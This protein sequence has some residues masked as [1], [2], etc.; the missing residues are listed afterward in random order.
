MPEP[1]RWTV[2]HG[3]FREAK[4]APESVDL[5]FTDPPYY[6]SLTYLY[7]DLGELAQRVL[8]PGGW[9][10]AYTGHL[11]LPEALSLMGRFGL[12]WGLP[13]CVRHQGGL[14]CLTKFN[15]W[16]HYKVILG[17]FKPPLKVRWE[18]FD[19]LIEGTREKDL[20]WMQQGQSEAERFIKHLCPAGGLVLDPMMG[21]GTTLAAALKLG[22]RCIGFDVDASAYEQ[23]R[24]WLSRTEEPRIL[25]LPA[26][27]G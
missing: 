21:S 13:L 22:L 12:Q 27:A 16:Q 15:V 1:V 26:A 5:I 4:I 18:A 3:D 10:L 14:L 17:F 2:K 25:P 20:H 7:Q 8:K 6:P 24:Q 23:A 11:I 9:C 19:D